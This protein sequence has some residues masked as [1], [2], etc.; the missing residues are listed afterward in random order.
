MVFKA[1]ETLQVSN[2][3]ALLVG[4]SHFD[5]EAAAAA[6]VQF[7]QYNIGGNERLDSVLGRLA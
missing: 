6:D 7:I 3:H 1:L 5:R 4:D 2:E